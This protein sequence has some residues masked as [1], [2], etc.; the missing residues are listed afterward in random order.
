METCWHQDI[1]RCVD[2]RAARRPTLTVFTF[3]FVHH[4]GSK[5]LFDGTEDGQKSYVLCLWVFFM[6]TSIRPP[7]SVF[8]ISH[9]SQMRISDAVETP[10]LPYNRC[11][12]FMQMEDVV[13][14]ARRHVLVIVG[15]VW[16]CVA[17]MMRRMTLNTGH[18]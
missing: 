10:S 11:F 6:A 3:F 16:K 17:C 18:E 1:L 9:C 12:F 8:T 2:H 4:R 5:K 14:A 13:F 7:F 15:G